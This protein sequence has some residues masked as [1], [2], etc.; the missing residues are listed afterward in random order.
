MSTPAALQEYEQRLYD[1]ISDSEL[2]QIY[3][4]AFQS[5][6]GLDLLFSAADEHQGVA[7][8]E[9]AAGPPPETPSHCLE[10]CDAWLEVTEALQSNGSRRESPRNCACF[11]SLSHTT[12]PVRVGSTAFAFLRVGNLFYPLP[13]EKDYHDLS[14]KLVGQGLRPGETQLLKKSYSQTQ[15]RDPARHS[16]VGALLE[17]LASELSRYTE[18]L[19]SAP[20]EHEPETIARAR[21]HIHAHLDQSL[22][23]AVVARRAGLS[24]SHFCRVFREVTGWTLTDYITQCR[25]GWAQRE[26]L[27]PSARISGVAFK[28]GF[29]SLS[30]FN[31][32]FARV[33]G[34]SPSAYRNAS[35]HPSPAKGAH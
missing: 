15:A 5:A 19:A 26:L 31:R 4:G 24:E 21:H 22:P 17:N 13:P 20:E 16:T 7:R 10:A 14:G 23:L 1:R 29:Q 32:S 28:V 25:I 34:C 2:F 3:Q 18:V 35:Q 11:Q 8:H 30:Q 27:R 12:T 6:T 9:M 33:V